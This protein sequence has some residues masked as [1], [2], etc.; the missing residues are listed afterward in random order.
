MSEKK[1]IKESDGAQNEWYEV[2]RKQTLETLPGFLNHVLNDYSHDQQTVIHAM[3]A[4]CMGTIS[5]M[6]AH[7]EGDISPAQAQNLLG[8]F[9]RKWAKIEGPAKIMSWAGFLHPGNE[10]QVVE[11]PRGIAEWLS[12]T[13]QKAIADGKYQDEAHKAHLEKIAAGE[14]PWGYRVAAK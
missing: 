10:S 7:P 5:A 6:N 1:F 12:Q 4:G 13:A 9:I 2:A 3:V 11:V 14:M 8:L